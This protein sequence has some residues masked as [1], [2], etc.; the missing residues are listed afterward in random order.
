MAIIDIIKSGKKGPVNSASGTKHKS[1]DEKLIIEFLKY[2]FLNQYL[3]FYVG[4]I[5]VKKLVQYFR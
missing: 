3:F 5:E 2:N 4:A 1:N